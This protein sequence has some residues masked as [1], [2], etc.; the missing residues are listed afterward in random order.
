VQK[1]RGCNFYWEKTGGFGKSVYNIN[2]HYYKTFFGSKC[3]TN[4]LAAEFKQAPLGELKA[5][6]QI[7][8][9]R[10]I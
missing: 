8:E 5:L 6:P 4:R 3:T 1:L 2:G 7:P 10:K 9:K